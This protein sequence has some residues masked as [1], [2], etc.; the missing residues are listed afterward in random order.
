MV[1][2]V[3]KKLTVDIKKLL[4]LLIIIMAGCSTVPVRDESEIPP[5]RTLSEFV[6]EGS[7]YP[8]DEYDPFEGLN[9]RI[10]KFNARFDEMVFLP[11][12]SGYEFI[13]P[14]F[15]Q[16]GVSSFFFNLTEVTNLLNSLLQF[17]GK[18]FGKTVT[19]VIINTTVGV[20]GVWDPATRMGIF[21]QNEDFGQTLGFYKVGSG[22]YLVLPFLGPSS[23]RDT[24]G[25]IVD[26][27]VYNAMLRELINVGNLK[28]GEEDKI[29]GGLLLLSA[30]DERH[31]EGFRY[32]ET[33]SPFEYELIRLF[34]L[35]KR[36]FLVE[37]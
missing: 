31:K 35:T 32:Y 23:L 37:H 20:G 13:L 9:R 30:I 27:L 24:G 21:R 14:D 16:K 1:I 17:K 8:I 29:Q 18:V 34:Y 25:L 11:V 22:P 15:A 28:T 5:K 6:T 19:R 3:V 33:G 2:A 36:R 26:S 7:D 4:I 10:Y 12:V